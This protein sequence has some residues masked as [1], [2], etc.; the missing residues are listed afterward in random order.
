MLAKDVRA[1]LVVVHPLSFGCLL[2]Q[3][4]GCPGRVSEPLLLKVD[5][6]ELKSSQV[7]LLGFLLSLWMAK[8]DVECPVALEWFVLRLLCVDLVIV[9]EEM[10]SPLD[11]LTQLSPRYLSLIV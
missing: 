8:E 10:D 2:R 3:A 4:L 5:L 1:V 7:C 11:P 6:I 9:E